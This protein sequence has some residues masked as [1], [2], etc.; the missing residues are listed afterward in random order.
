MPREEEP[1]PWVRPRCSRPLHVL[2]PLMGSKAGWGQGLLPHLVNARPE[3]HPCPRPPGE[4]E[5]T[6]TLVVA[7]HSH[8]SKGSSS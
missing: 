1:V 4:G 2:C 5:W 3:A 8:L 6:P 7:L